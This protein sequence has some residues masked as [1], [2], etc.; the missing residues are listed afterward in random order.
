MRL[1][2]KPPI[3]TLKLNVMS[4]VKLG[5]STLTI[6]QKIIKA[7]SVSS[8]MAANATVYVAPDPPLAELD[9]AIG[10]LAAAQ[11][12]AIKGGTDR[13]V[14]RNARLNELTDLMNRLV[15]YVQLTSGGDPEL[16]AL[17]GMEVRKPREPWPVPDRVLGLEALPGG[18]PGTI[19]LSWEPARY[20]KQYVLEMFVEGDTN[21]P[22]DPVNPDGTYPTGAWEVVVVQGKRNFMAIG[23][24]QGKQYRFRVAAINSSG[25]GTYSD[26]ATSVAS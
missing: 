25:M 5:W 2:I 9:A 20:N 22:D 8:T 7:T 3:L 18:N 6:S 11:S 4:K 23:L 14:A 13:T 10:A 26:E 16:I 21:P 24:Q 19:E 17:A 12:E 15:D 1:G